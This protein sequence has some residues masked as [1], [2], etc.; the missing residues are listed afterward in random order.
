MPEKF[1]RIGD[2]LNENPGLAPI[3]KIIKQSD[4]IIGFYD[5][6][7]ELKKV[8]KPVKVE[9]QT[10]FI[11]VENSIL[12]SELRFQE[13]LI[14]SKVNNYFKEERIKGIKFQ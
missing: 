6:F 5:I 11:K 8:V 2:I 4:V 10:L 7:P 1:K 13:N 14:V 9:K 12:R 3:R